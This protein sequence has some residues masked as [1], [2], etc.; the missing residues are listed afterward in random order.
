MSLTIQCSEEEE[1]R[2]ETILKLNQ[3]SKQVVQV[4]RNRDYTLIVGTTRKNKTANLKAHCPMFQKGKDEG[5]FLVLGDIER[6]ELLALRRVSGVNGPLRNN[7]LMFTAPSVLGKPPNKQD[8]QNKTKCHTFFS[9]NF[10]FLSGETVLTF[11]LVSDCYIGMDQ[12]Y[13]IRLNVVE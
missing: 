3:G 12:Q 10:L 6:R 1:E 7:Q 5:W 9:D 13:E 2:L 11:Y 4:R 8:Y